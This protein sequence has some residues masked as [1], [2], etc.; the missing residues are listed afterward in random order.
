MR[1]HYRFTHTCG[2]TGVGPPISGK[3]ESS[4]SL[5]K[6]TIIYLTLP[7]SCPF[8]PAFKC[9]SWTRISEVSPGHGILTI[10]SPTYPWSWIV[11]RSCK[12]EDVTIQDWA[13]STSENSG[14]RQMAWIPK[15]CGEV[16]VAGNLEEVV[17][18]EQVVTDMTREVACAWR[19][20]ADEPV[21]SRFA[22]LLSQ[23]NAAILSGDRSRR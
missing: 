8:C 23:F 3:S 6:L 1:F 14:Y 10:M 9:S 12:Y 7:F 16:R 21:E 20:R 11:M 13:L 18:A 15:P 2:H 22:G 4:S 17:R 5:E 19:Q